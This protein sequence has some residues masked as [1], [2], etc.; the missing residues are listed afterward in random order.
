MGNHSATVISALEKIVTQHHQKMQLFPSL[1]QM[2][3]NT[4]LS[5]IAIV[6]RVDLTIMFLPILGFF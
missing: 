6:S 1:S 4:M 2:N 3:N 5:F